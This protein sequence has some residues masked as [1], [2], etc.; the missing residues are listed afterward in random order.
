MAKQE[1]I[2]IGLWIPAEMRDQMKT[3]AEKE[4]WSLSKLTEVA[5][6]YYL[7]LREPKK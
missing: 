5:V 4:R 7:K 6:E 3:L 2:R 1:K